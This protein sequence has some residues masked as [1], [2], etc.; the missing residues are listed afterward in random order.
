MCRARSVQLAKKLGEIAVARLRGRRL[1]G[2]AERGGDAGMGWRN[3]HADDPALQVQCRHLNLLACLVHV[4][5]T[6]TGGVS[7]VRFE[8]GTARHIG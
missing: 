7:F 6:M 2:T 3:I 8:P 4:G 1:E 5:E